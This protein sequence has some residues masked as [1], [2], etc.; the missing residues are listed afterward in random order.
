MNEEAARQ[1]LGHHHH[2]IPVH[3]D[4]KMSLHILHPR[5]IPTHLK[6]DLQAVEEGRM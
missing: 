5:G 3:F 6:K 2:C 4:S 1:R